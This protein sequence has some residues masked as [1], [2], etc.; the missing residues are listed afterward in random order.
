MHEYDAPARLDAHEIVADIRGAH[1]LL[2]ED[3]LINQQV[4]K[5]VLNLAGF[6]VE[7][8]NNGQQAIDLLQRDSFD[9][10][11]MDLHMPVMDGFTASR[12]I[13]KNPKFVDLPIIAM[14]A[15]AMAKDRDDCLAAGMND[16]VTKPIIAHELM[17]TLARWVKNGR[18]F[19]GAGPIKTASLGAVK[20]P[21]KLPGFAIG[22]A[23]VLLGGNHALLSKV[24]RQF[25]EI[26][27]NSAPEMKQFIATGKRDEAAALAHLIRGAAGNT[28]A[29]ELHAAATALE[30]EIAGGKP[31]TSLA[32]FE[33]ALAQVLASIALLAEVEPSFESAPDCDPCRWEDSRGLLQHLRERKCNIESEF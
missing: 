9:A 21:A 4:A 29:K 12:E 28:G 5:E 15:A 18:P 19:A 6:S 30:Q 20:L 2:V 31:I 26:F 3:N 7:I 27:A 23:L 16:H 10:V 22:D 8:A 33:R 11:L 17:T 25:G 13:R 14:T 24:M 32:L 1:L